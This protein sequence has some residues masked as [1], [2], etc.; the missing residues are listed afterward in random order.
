MGKLSNTYETHHSGSH[1]LENPL[2][3]TSL[4]DYITSLSRPISLSLSAI[5]AILFLSLSHNAN[6]RTVPS[7]PTSFFFSLSLCAKAI[8]DSIQL[9]DD[10]TGVGLERDMGSCASLHRNS[11]SESAMKFRLSFRSKDD[12][13]VIPPSSIKENPTNGNP[14]THNNNN[15]VAAKSQWPASRSTTSFGGY[16]MYGPCYCR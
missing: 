10:R 2:T 13:L 9:R 7:S 3:L 12:K 14:P 1:F 5:S 11:D 6:N 4:L 8:S 15:V 16:G